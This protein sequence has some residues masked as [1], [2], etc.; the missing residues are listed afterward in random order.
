MDSRI[1]FFLVA[2]YLQRC[3]DYLCIFLI[4]INYFMQQFRWFHRK[5]RKWFVCE[6]FWN[7]EICN[8]SFYFLVSDTCRHASLL[9][10]SSFLLPLYLSLY[11][12]TAGWHKCNKTT[13]QNS[14][15]IFRNNSD[16]YIKM[17]GYLTN[18]RRYFN[19]CLVK[20]I[21]YGMNILPFLPKLNMNERIW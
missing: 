7:I 16:H 6:R 3:I 8:D 5:L 12:G 20:K 14:F 17:V 4:F 2:G 15:Y 21:L 13:K 18:I 19:S 11:T 10:F 1:H 9:P